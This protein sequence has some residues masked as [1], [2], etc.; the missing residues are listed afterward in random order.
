M[1][2]IQKRLLDRIDYRILEILIAVMLNTAAS[3]LLSQTN[4]LLFD[5]FEFP[6][7]TL[8]F[9]HLVMCFVFILLMS[10][11]GMI[12]FAPMPFENMV[13]MSLLLAANVF[14]GISSLEYNS[15]GV[16]QLFKVLAIYGVMFLAI[17][18]YDV[19]FSNS[20]KWCT[21]SGQKCCYFINYSSILLRFLKS[22]FQW[23]LAFTSIRCFIL[24]SPS[25]VV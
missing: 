24:N 7:L 23:S 11:F 21:V 15:V 13:P 20:V 2:K 14:L 5:L 17:Q 12:K 19:S 9:V 25:L 10:Q 22:R 18:F 1:L 3:M 4:K 6:K 8:S 16:Y